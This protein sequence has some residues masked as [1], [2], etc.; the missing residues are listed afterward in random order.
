ME[1]QRRHPPQAASI[2]CVS[3]SSVADEAGDGQR[4]QQSERHGYN[5][6]IGVGRR[7]H[8]WRMA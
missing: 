3:S 5:T 7:A 4:P 8:A 6:I 2:H 1:R